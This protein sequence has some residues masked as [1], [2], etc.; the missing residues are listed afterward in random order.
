MFAHNGVHTIRDNTDRIRESAK[1]GT[2]LFV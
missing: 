2:E 1:S